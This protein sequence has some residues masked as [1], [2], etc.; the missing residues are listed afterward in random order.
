MSLAPIA[1]FAY[2]RPEHLRRTLESLAANDLAA[3]S[4]LFVFSDGAR[5][6]ADRS[7]V[8]AVR[9]Y[10]STLTG[11]KEVVIIE[12]ERNLGLAASIIEG[13]TRVVGQFGRVIVLEDDMVTSPYFLRYMNEALEMYQ[14]EERV[15]S[16]HG[17]LYPVKARLPETF[18]LKGADCWGWGTWS[19]AWKLFNPDGSALLGILKQR[20]LEH[21]FDCCGCFPYTQMLKDQIS[22]KI[23]SW[24]IRWHASAF[25]LDKLTLYPGRSLICN[26][27]CDFS[28]THCLA[29]DDYRAD[30]ASEPVLHENIPVVEHLAARSALALFLK[31]IR[32]TF[33]GRVWQIVKLW[34]GAR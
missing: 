19:R 2:Q 34:G 12:R 31:S 13:V 22:G 5:S 20:G 11:F 25:V 16:I 24:A 32:P 3:A 15:I 7:R 14:N 4:T 17:Y 8:E 9:G 18:F 1:L 26:I 27:G 23:N 21:E 33:A 28:G 6:G 30:I 29:S 10:L